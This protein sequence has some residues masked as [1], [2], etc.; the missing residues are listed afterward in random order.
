MGGVL[1]ILVAEDS[2]IIATLIATMLRKRGFRPDMVENG[3]AAVDAVASKHYDIV[4]MDVNM[5]EL[6]G[7][8]AARMIRTLP[9]P[10]SRIPIIALTA[11]VLA[12]QRESYLAAGMDDYVAKPI[13]PAALFMAIERWAGQGR[14]T[15]DAHLSASM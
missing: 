12:E 2:P 10:A 8:S 9:G 11:N 15:A 5:P 14:E 13:Q 1:D 6:D 3:L 4:L 7:L